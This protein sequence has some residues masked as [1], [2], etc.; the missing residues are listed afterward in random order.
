RRALAPLLF[1]NETLVEARRTRDPVAKAGPTRRAR[2]KK[3]RRRTDDGRPLQNLSTLLAELAMHRRNTC[4]VAA[5]PTTPALTT[6]LTE[7]TATQRQARELIQTFPVP[8]T[9]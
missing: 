7:P 8:G 5:D 2:W 3:A 4:R 1:D 6:L 9:A